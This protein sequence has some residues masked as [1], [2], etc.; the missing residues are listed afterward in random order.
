MGRRGRVEKRYFD[1][2]VN[3]VSDKN[4]SNGVSYINL[5][6][7]LYNIDFTY[8]IKMDE[9]RAK[10][11][12]RLRHRFADETGLDIQGVFDDK[13]CSVLE[14]ILALMVRCEEHIMHDPE[15]GDRTAQWFWM[16]ITNLGLI[17]MTDSRFKKEKVF[18]H[19]HIFLNREYEADGTNGLFPIQNCRYDL[20]EVEIWY[21]MCWYLD[22][23]S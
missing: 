13:P 11:G 18:E 5:L 2:M 22:G 7:C 12:V 10:D 21:Q 17:S 3:I 20:R 9:N 23:M 8:I 19:I 4:H 14:M 15:Y 1:W 6:Y 16:V